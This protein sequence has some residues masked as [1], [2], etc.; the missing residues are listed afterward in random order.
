[1]SKSWYEFNRANPDLVEVD[2]RGVIGLGEIEPLDFATEL[3]AVSA[4]RVRVNINSPG[5]GISAG[6]DIYNELRAFS[7]RGGTVETYNAA[8]AASIASVIMLGGDRRIAAPHSRMMIHEASTIAMG[9]ASDFE[10]EAEVLR[11]L[12]ATIAQIYQER[13][14]K[15]AAYW[16][17]LMDSETWLTDKQA[18]DEGFATEIGRGY[19]AQNFVTASG[20]VALNLFRAWPGFDPEIAAAVETN[21]GRVM[22]GANM[23]R[24]SS[25]AASHRSVADELDQLVSDLGG[26]KDEATEPATNTAPAAP[27]GDPAPSLTRHEARRIAV[28]EILAG[29]R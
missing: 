19:D 28:D 12:T 25:I 29:I 21:A 10:K 2:L 26:A 24:L 7:E 18:L 3:R 22:S 9:R 13:T 5:G 4:P 17:P 11:G 1:M 6:L 16:L 15:P 23:T 27:E 20:F 8:L 14:G